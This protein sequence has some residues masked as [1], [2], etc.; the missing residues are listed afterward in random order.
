MNHIVDD[1][2]CMLDVPRY[3]LNVGATSKGIVAGDLQF[4]SVEGNLVV[5]C[6]DVPTVVETISSARTHAL[7][8]TLLSLGTVGAWS[9]SYNQ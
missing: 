2:A 6:R 7:P 5:D 1:I 9:Y 4:S 3:V 8:L